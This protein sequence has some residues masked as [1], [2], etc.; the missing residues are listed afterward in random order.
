MRCTCTA[1]DRV[2]IPA[3]PPKLNEMKPISPKEARDSKVKVI[4]PGIIEAVNQLII[5]K[6]NGKNSFGIKQ[7]D[8][9]KLFVQANPDYDTDLLFKEHHMDFESVYEKEGWKVYYDK[10]GFNETHYDPIYNFSIKKDE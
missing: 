5:Q 4:H 6:F 10:P 2:R 9:L 1:E 3:C 8:I 7:G